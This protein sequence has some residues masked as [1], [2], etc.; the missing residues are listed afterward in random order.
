[1]SIDPQPVTLEGK[2][3]RLEPP[4]LA[5]TDDLYASSQF[6]EIWEWWLSPPPQSRQEMQASIEQSIAGMEKGDRIW[7][8]M[9]RRAD[10]RAVGVTSYLNI[11]R[12]DGCLEIG[13]T[14][15]TPLAWRT[16]INTESKYLLLKHAFENLGC[17]RVQLK[18]DERNTRSRRAIERLGAKPEGV[19]RKYQMLANG[20][21]RNSAMYSILDNEWANVKVRLEQFMDEGD[22]T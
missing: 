9:I 11:Q 1:M 2:F 20:F 10:D 7:F 4:S 21:H 22:H 13:G 16:S 5:Q 17:V 3:V 12:Y 15:L 8:T 6:P 19:L 18:T 14:W